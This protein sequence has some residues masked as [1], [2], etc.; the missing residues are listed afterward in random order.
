MIRTAYKK[1]IIQ[2]PSALMSVFLIGATSLMVIDGSACSTVSESSEIL[3]REKNRMRKPTYLLGAAIAL[4]I[5]V[6][7]TMTTS[8][9]DRAANNVYLPMIERAQPGG[10]IPSQ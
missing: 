6:Y 2:Y 9:E 5:V 7:A 10:T 8:A 3:L 4:V 1:E